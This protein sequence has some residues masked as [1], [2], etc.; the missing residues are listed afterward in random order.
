VIERDFA[1]ASIMRSATAPASARSAAAQAVLD[2]G[3]GRS[4]Q[5]IRHRGEEDAAPIRMESL[6]EHQ[7]EMLINRVR[8]G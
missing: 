2:R 5:S 4:L 1:L 7:L 3:F 8:K 6:S